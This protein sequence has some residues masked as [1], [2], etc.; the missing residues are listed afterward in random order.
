MLTG[1]DHLL[2][3]LCIFLKRSCCQLCAGVVNSRRY[4][5]SGWLLQVTERLTNT[6]ICARGRYEN[7]SPMELQN[8]VISNG[9]E[10]H[11]K[12]DPLRTSSKSYLCL[13]TLSLVSAC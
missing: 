12:L 5:V 2:V 9:N 4:G 1:T 11:H 13:L 8:E 10:K 3:G 7:P 6:Q